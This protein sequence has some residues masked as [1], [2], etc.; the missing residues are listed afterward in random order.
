MKNTGQPDPTRNPIDPFKNDPFWPVIRLIRQ[1][2][3]PNPNPTRPACFATSTQNHT[4]VFMPC[5]MKIVQSS[6]F[7]LV[8]S[9]VCTN[10]NL[11]P[12][13]FRKEDHYFWHKSHGWIDPGVF[14]QG[15]G[16]FLEACRLSNFYLFII[17]RNNAI[18]ILNWWN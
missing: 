6:K 10:T 18:N 16:A 2:D 4:F 3:W 13:V 8:C 11:M 1:P 14:V 5:R 15:S 7:K 9:A 12:V 17:F